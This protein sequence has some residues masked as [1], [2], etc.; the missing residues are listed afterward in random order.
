MPYCTRCGQELG[1][2]ARF[3]SRCGTSV[4][5]AGAEEDH[6]VERISAEYPVTDSARLEIV[7]GV[8]HSI[9]VRP[10]AE[11]F[12]EGAV[13][14]E[15]PEWKPWIDSQGDTVHIEQQQSYLPMLRHDSF[16]RWRLKIGNAKPFSLSVRS[17]IGRGTWSLGGLPIT[18][19]RIETGA[20]ENRFSFMSI[21]PQVMND[22]EVRA[23]V[24]EIRLE[25]LLDANFGEMRVSGA[26]GSI[27]LDFSGEKLRRDCIIHLEGGVGGVT[28]E[29]PENTPARVR[30]RGLTGVRSLGTFRRTGGTFVDSEYQTEAYNSGAS[31][32]IEFTLDMGVGGVTLRTI[33]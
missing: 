6:L 17:G 29:M 32:R 16:N 26:V 22:L 15:I 4:G 13:E 33:R 18:S 23:G 10:G 21:N 20:G 25:G 11:K 2:D 8:A 5:G 28:I 9:E 7:S 12:V 27:H 3:C 24:G 30:I 1:D 14:Y 19:L 31:P